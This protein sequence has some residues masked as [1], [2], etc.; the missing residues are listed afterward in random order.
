[1]QCTLNLQNL[2]CSPSNSILWK[3]FSRGSGVG[4]YY[5]DLL[6]EN[7]VIVE[8]KAAEAIC[9][10]HEAQLVHYLR[11]TELEVG[12][13]LNF[14]KTPEFKRKV[15]TQEFKTNPKRS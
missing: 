11:A 9:E 10:E 15:L 4:K 8:L 2:G 14:G 6:V 12:L 5:A 1:M 7:K 13:L 3:Y